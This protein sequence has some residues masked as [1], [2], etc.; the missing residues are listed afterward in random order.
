MSKVLILS[1]KD[2][3]THVR[4]LVAE[5]DKLGHSWTLFDPGGFPAHVQ[6]TA[7]LSNGEK[8]SSIL[9]NGTRLF[10]EDITSVWYRRP[11]P[12][13]SKEDLSALEKTFIEREAD[14]GLWGWLRGVNAF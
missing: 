8:H 13:V 6:F 7:S 12:I 4:D 5:L 3:D 2:E 10:F 14:A 11:T 1:N 9:I